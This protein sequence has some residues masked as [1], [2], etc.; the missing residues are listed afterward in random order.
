MTNEDVAFAGVSLEDSAQVL[1]QGI[2]CVRSCDLGGLAGTV[3]G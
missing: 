2:E 1:C 3:A